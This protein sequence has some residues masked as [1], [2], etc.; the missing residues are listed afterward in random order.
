MKNWMMFGLL[1]LL[2]FAGCN[3]DDEPLPATQVQIDQYIADNSITG[4]MTTSS[5]LVYIIDEPG[6]AEKPTVADEITINYKGYLTDDRVFDETTGTPRTFPLSRLIQ[7]WQE[8]IPLIGKG[9]KIKL[10]CPPEL[11]Y[12]NNPPAGSIIRAGS[13]LVFDIELLDF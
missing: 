10:I 5:G 3:G 13:V 6:E 2:A 1:S 9:G 11:A 8:G 12:G 4:E 7:A